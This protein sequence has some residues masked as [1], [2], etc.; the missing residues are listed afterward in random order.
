M[1]N[2]NGNTGTAQAAYDTQ[3]CYCDPKQP[4]QEFGAYCLNF[5]RHHYVVCAPHAAAYSGTTIAISVA[6]ADANYTTGSRALAGRRPSGVWRR[7]RNTLLV[8]P[9]PLRLLSAQS[10]R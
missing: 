10:N 7:W 6:R 2:L 5:G 4:E 9:G 1:S 8:E 3:N